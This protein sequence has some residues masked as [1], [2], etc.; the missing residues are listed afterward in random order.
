V[1]ELYEEAKTN[2]KNIKR[3]NLIEVCNLEGDDCINYIV[4]KTNSKGQ[5]NLIMTADEDINQMIK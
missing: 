3:I 4:N 1:F 2:I 5:S